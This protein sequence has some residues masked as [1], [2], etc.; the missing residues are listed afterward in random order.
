MNEDLASAFLQA[1][2]VGWQDIASKTIDSKKLHDAVEALVAS[3]NVP[4]A[5]QTHLVKVLTECV[6]SA[7]FDSVKDMKMAVQTNLLRALTNG[8]VEFLKDHFRYAT[9]ISTMHSMREWCVC[10]DD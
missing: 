4:E 1:F 6:T 8:S 5:A 2:W 7:F 3:V 10:A 9:V